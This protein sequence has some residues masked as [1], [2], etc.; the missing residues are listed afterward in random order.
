MTKNSHTREWTT[1]GHSLVPRTTS[2][3]CVDNNA[4][5]RKSGENGEGLG[6]FTVSDIEWAGLN[7]KYNVSLNTVKRSCLQHLQFPL[8]LECSNLADWTMNWSRTS[9]IDYGACPPPQTS[10]WPHSCDRPSTFSAALPLL[11]IIVNTTEE[12]Q[13]RTSNSTSL[14]D[15]LG[16]IQHELLQFRALPSLQADA[17]IF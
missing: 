14:Q 10:T 4:R 2:L 17:W 5:K 16:L 12:K 1:A 11:C 9:R 13:G 7:R 6:E 15:N 3:D 8:V